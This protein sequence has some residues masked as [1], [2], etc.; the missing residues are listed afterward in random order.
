MNSSLHEKLRL[1]IQVPPLYM[2]NNEC[3]LTLK[4]IKYVDIQHI[5]YACMIILA[6]KKKKKS[7]STERISF[8]T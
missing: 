5:F 2:Q 6:K 8:E 7:C 1:E 3:A 4:N